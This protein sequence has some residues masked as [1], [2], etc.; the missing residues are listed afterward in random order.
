MH[1]Y[2]RAVLKYEVLN[3]II[4]DL[5]KQSSPKISITKFSQDHNLIIREM[6]KELLRR[7]NESTQK[8]FAFDKPDFMVEKNVVKE[9]LFNYSNKNPYWMRPLLIELGYSK[10]NPNPLFK[11]PAPD[12]QSAGV[13]ITEE[14]VM[15]KA[16]EFGWIDEKTGELTKAG[17]SKRRIKDML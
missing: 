13:P 4:L 1:E 3:R 15:K 2:V 12:Y 11:E 14:E 6:D 5:I 9:F 17:R 10:P 16:I 8:R 7:A